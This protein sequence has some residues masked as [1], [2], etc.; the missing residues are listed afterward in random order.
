VKRLSLELFAEFKGFLHNI[1][2]EHPQPSDLAV[3][4]VESYKQSLVLSFGN[5]FCDAKYIERMQTVLLMLKQNENVLDLED[6]ESF[7]SLFQAFHL[8]QTKPFNV[9]F[10]L[11]THQFPQALLEFMEI[12]TFLESHTDQFA[13]LADP[14]DIQHKPEI[15][16]YLDKL[17]KQVPTQKEFAYYIE[18]IH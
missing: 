3:K 1:N 18:E 11:Q 5:I 4:S 2:M 8:R 14:K 16:F 7:C 15:I 17:L 9:P 12:C 13:Y 10:L 6:I